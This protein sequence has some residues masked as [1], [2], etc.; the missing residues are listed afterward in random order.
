MT[1]GEV[2]AEPQPAG[3]F[4]V[5][6]VSKY[7]RWRDEN[8]TSIFPV[9]VISLLKWATLCKVY[10]RINHGTFSPFP[11]IYRQQVNDDDTSFIH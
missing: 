2:G 1:Q 9:L 3:S 4:F 5:I 10:L 7:S 6:S 11:F 8:F